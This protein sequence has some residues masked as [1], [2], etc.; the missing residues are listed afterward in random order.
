[1]EHLRQLP[2]WVMLSRRRLLGMVPP[3]RCQA[4]RRE[5]NSNAPSIAFTHIPQADPARSARNDIFEGRVAK[6]EDRAVRKTGKWWVQPLVEQPMT[7]LRT[8]FRWPNATHLGTHH[9][10]LLVANGYRPHSE[11]A[12]ALAEV[13]S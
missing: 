2:A 6:P 10:A 5:P 11:L 8:K 4:C 3:G 7:D 1:M 12:G 9:A 13:A